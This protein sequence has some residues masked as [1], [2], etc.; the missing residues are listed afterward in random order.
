MDF[1]E[2]E[3]RE[4]MNEEAIS[5][6]ERGMD[7]LYLGQL[8]PLNASIY[9]IE[10]VLEFPFG[11]FVSPEDT[12]FLR[13]LVDN[14]YNAGLLT[15]TR[16]AT[17]SGK[18]LYTLLQFKN[19][20]AQQINDEFKEDFQK[21]LKRAKFDK[22]TQE[23]LE[24]ARGLR[25]T[26]VAHIKRDLVLGNVEQDR[27]NLVEL[28]ALR[29][30]LNFLLEALSFNKGRLMLPVQYHPDVVHPA[31][32]DSHSDIQQILDHVARDSNILNLPE[33]NPHHWA[34]FRKNLSEEN[35]RTIN[36][37]RAKFGL[38]EVG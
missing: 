28:K 31:G 19:W 16:L 11:L 6:Y 3:P 32:A 24:K 26:S 4:V 37:Y 5:E 25:N 17:D 1:S 8:V 10:Q 23:M 36:R 18:D 29:D 38:P 15:I 7:F 30:A 33:K 22:K 9:I 27:L 13:L 12:T 21:H 20:V 35:L 2:L 14:F 34:A